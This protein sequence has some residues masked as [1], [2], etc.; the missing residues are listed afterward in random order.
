MA[1]T[2]LAV[3]GLADASLI[4]RI[5]FESEAARR[6]CDDIFGT[7]Y[8]WRLALATTERVL[9]AGPAPPYARRRLRFSVLGL[10]C[11]RLSRG[12]VL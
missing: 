6:L 5:P 12:S 4:T 1:P 7:I 9:S 10:L 11:F 3:H 8:V 2:G